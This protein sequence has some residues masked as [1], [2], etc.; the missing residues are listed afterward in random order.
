MRLHAQAPALAALPIRGYKTLHIQ[1]QGSIQEK[2]RD[3]CQ[4]VRTLL[5]ES[6]VKQQAVFASDD[7]AFDCQL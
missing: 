4:L 5:R 1:G 2:L 6:L 3:F 7:T